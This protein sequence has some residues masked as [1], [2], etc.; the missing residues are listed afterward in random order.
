MAGGAG[1][2]PLAPPP[3]LTGAPSPAGCYLRGA[4]RMT[5]QGRAG[6]AV[7]AAVTLAL[8]GA[9]GTPY[10]HG[11][12]DTTLDHTLTGAPGEGF[13]DIVQGPPSPRVVRTL[14]DAAPQPNRDRRRRSLAYFAQ[15]TDFLLAD[16]ESPARVEFLDRDPSGTAASAWRPQEAFQPEAI[17]WSFRQLDRFTAASPVTQ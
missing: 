17:D 12:G 6:W 9:G 4:G 3:V 14:G 2:R 10:A 1:R 13:V 5:R 8:A 7:A 15:L 11:L 16:E